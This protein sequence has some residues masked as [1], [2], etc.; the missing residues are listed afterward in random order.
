MERFDVVVVGAGVMGTATARSLARRGARV[1]LLERFFVG[2]PHGSSHGRSR[3]FRLSYPDPYYVGL[4]QE[5]RELWKAA[6]AEAGEDLL[7]TTGGFDVGKGIEANAA[8][9]KERDAPFEMLTPAEAGRRFPTTSFP[10][11][12]DVLFQPDGG[13]AL[14]DRAVESFV[15]SAIRN[16]AA[17]F[18]RT[19]AVELDVGPG[20]AVHTE[21][22]TFLADVVVVTAGGWAKGLL[23]PVGIDIPTRVSRETVAFFRHEGAQPPTVVEWRVPHIYGLPSPG[24]GIKAGEH[25]AG[26]T[27]DPDERGGFDPEAV[28]R[29]AEWVRARFPDAEAQPHYSETCLYTNTPDESFILERIGAFVVGSPCSGHGFKFAPAIG[30]RLADLAL[31]R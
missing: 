19:R 16:G 26:P 10:E 20:A 11:G 24:Q 22:G 31:A 8:A 27:V 23:A 28:A 17:L 2:H 1:A 15:A 18:E 13:I 5:A 12:A 21:S 4:A 14:A 9:L 3:I 7:V 30:E 29:L 6:S 25:I